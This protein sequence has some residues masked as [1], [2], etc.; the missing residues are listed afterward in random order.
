MNGNEGEEVME[1][2]CSQFEEI[3]Q[4]LDRPGT[5]GF[6]LRESALAHAESCAPCARLMMQTES[7]GF[8]LREIAA[9][10]AAVAPPRTEEVLLLE[11]RRQKAERARLTYRKLAALATAAA[12][13]AAL[14]IAFFRGRLNPNPAP[15]QEAIAGR[16]TPTFAGVGNTKQEP[17]GQTAMTQAGSSEY[18]TA[19]VPLPYADDPAT[20]NGGVVV[21]VL[22]SRTALVSLGLPVADV[23]ASERIPADIVLS[24]DGAPQAI[25]L[26]SQASLDQ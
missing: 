18:A 26:V 12:V 17:E 2:G 15:A 25:R 1:I 6:A 8:C 16:S 22:L 21:R 5:Q 23:G 9:R 10:N 3:L 4:D 19:F 7:L 24:E 14:G 20:L 13:L 11:F